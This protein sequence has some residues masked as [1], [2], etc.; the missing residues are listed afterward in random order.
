MKYNTI[1]QTTRQMNRK[2]PKH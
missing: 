2:S 1:N